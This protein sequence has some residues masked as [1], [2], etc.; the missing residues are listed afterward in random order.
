MRREA[1]KDNP[2]S[3]AWRRWRK[4]RKALRP[5]T[6][7]LAGEERITGTKLSVLA[8]GNFKN[9]AKDM[10]YLIRSVL[11]EHSSQRSAGAEWVWRLSRQAQ[12]QDADLIIVAGLPYSV[13]RLMKFPKAFFVPRWIDVELDFQA[14]WER[15][16]T[17]TYL[18]KEL[19]KIQTHHFEYEVTRD[20]ELKQLFYHRMH[21]PYIT[22]RFGESAILRSYSTMME[23]ADCDL[24]LIKY[25]GEYIAGSVLEYRCGA[26]RAR[27]LG[28]VDGRRDYVRI[29][30]ISA[31]YY[32]ELHYLSGRGYTK[33][34][35]G[36]SWPFVDDGA[37]QYKLRWGGRIGRAARSGFLIRPVRR[38]ASVEAFLLNH[39]FL[40]LTSGGVSVCVFA[41]A[42]QVAT[43]EK[44]ESVTGKFM[45]PGVARL[46]LYLLDS[47]SDAVSI[48]RGGNNLVRIFPAKALF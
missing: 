40:A 48:P 27:I 26:A 41:R 4:V 42:N 30:A 18:R 8:A 3:W 16:R 31:I 39:P 46:D 35:R 10:S 21:V 11:R 47:G 15:L 44:L 37:L 32:F 6:R 34:H 14:A 28:V 38:N 24:L 13:Y 29:G 36:R 2:V 33:M 9:K 1:V 43:P 12:Q 45:L 7:L 20:A 25:R 19:K 22:N 5:P 17:S 23:S